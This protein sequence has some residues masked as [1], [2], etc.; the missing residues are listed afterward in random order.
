VT[1]ETIDK[2]LKPML[3]TDATGEQEAVDGDEAL[4]EQTA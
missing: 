4:G 2:G 3:V 1:R